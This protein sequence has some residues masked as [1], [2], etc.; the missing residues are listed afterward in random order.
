[1]AKKPF[2]ALINYREAEEIE[3]IRA[4]EEAAIFEA[5]MAAQEAVATAVAHGILSQVRGIQFLSICRIKRSLF[6]VILYLHLKVLS[7]FV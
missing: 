4:A 5:E 3:V 1:M 6:K 2:H 7:H